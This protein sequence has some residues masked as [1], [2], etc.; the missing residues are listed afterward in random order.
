[1]EL[2]LADILTLTGAAVAAGLVTS[3]VEV[4]KL[5][6]RSL[7]PSLVAG[8]EQTWALLVS[9]ALVIAAFVDQAVYVPGQAF[10]AFVAWLAIAKLATGIHDEV[11]RA[12]GSIRAAT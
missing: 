12:P 9:M 2:Q 1:M 11:T 8:K 3:T 10:S 5:G 6:T 7:L 4:L